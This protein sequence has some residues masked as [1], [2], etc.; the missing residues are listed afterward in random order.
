MERRAKAGAHL[1]GSE[2]DDANLCNLRL[3]HVGLHCRSEGRD[4]R[5]LVLL[6]QKGFHRGRPFLETSESG[7]SELLLGTRLLRELLVVR[8]E[9][10]K[11]RAVYGHDR[12]GGAVVRCRCN[13]SPG[14]LGG[15][16]VDLHPYCI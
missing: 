2:L 6:G 13:A 8:V 1:E 12:G 14:A 4:D 7:Q 3:P 9:G 5:C 16:V 11:K 10:R 15:L